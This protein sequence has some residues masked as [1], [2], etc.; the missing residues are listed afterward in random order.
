MHLRSIACRSLAALVMAAACSACATPSDSDH[1]AQVS[2]STADCRARTGRLMLIGGALDDDNHPVYMR[3]LSVSARLCW[4]E[5]CAL[6]PFTVTPPSVVVMTAASGDPQASA[7]NLTANILAHVPNSAV[8]V[9]GKA[10]SDAESVELIQNAGG[11]FFS[12]GDQKRITDR[13]LDHTHP[14]EC[15]PVRAALADLLNRC[16]VVA[17]T[18]AGAAMMGDVM[19]LGGSSAEALGVRDAEPADPA[20]PNDAAQPAPRCGARIGR[21][22]GLL[23]GVLTDSHFFERDRIGRMLVALANP[24]IPP[25]RFGLGVAENACVEVELPAMTVRGVSRAPSLLIDAANLRREGTKWSGARVLL[26]TEGREFRLADAA[27]HAANPD[28]RAATLPVA[29]LPSVPGEKPRRRGSS[30]RLFAFAADHPGALWTLDLGGWMVRAHCA[31][32]QPPDSTW[33]DVEVEV[34]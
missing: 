12:G 19:F 8:S 32:G 14:D 31:A 13:Y 22:M 30:G 7:D 23:P 2:A 9:V 5:S 17:G 16:G 3:F 27:R 6:T 10:T 20:D 4:A 28:A 15:T 25:P 26:L 21:G 29:P 1:A 24:A 34:Q 33:I 11:A 18:S